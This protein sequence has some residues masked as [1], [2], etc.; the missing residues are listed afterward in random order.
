MQEI[1]N[2]IIEILKFYN[3]KE[4]RTENNSVLFKHRNLDSE[5]SLIELENQNILIR[6]RNEY[7]YRSFKIRDKNNIAI[8]IQLFI[9]ECIK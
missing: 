9:K 3:I 7:K 1:I 5:I 6:F 2:R 8:Y 4:A